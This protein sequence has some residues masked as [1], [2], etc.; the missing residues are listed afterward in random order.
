M[1]LTTHPKHKDM[2]AQF[3]SNSFSF[4]QTTRFCRK[5]LFCCWEMRQS[6]PFHSMSV[7]LYFLHLCPPSPSLHHRFLG[8]L[9]WLLDPV[10]CFLFKRFQ[11]IPRAHELY[12]HTS[13]RTFFIPTVIFLVT[14][15]QSP[16]LRSCS[17]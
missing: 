14:C 9:H 15:P 7:V 13:L 8:Q 1:T 17:T 2:A 12:C 11:L 3:E 16:H 6:T 5:F 10:P 4:P